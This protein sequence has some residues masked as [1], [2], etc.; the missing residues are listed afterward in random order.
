MY[1][2]L[3]SLILST[4]IIS[5]MMVKLVLGNIVLSIFLLF[6]LQVPDHDDPFEEIGWPS[7]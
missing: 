3:S 4:A 2:M 6:S 7:Y 1:H 5:R